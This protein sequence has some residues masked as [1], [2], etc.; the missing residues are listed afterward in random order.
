[1]K[2]MSGLWFAI[3]TQVITSIIF[4]FNNESYEKAMIPLFFAT[5]M[6]ILWTLININDKLKPS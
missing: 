6:I 5:L 3:S 2:K 1:M 4:A